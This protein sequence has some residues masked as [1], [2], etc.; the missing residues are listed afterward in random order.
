MTNI[1]IQTARAGSKSVPNKNELKFNGV[2]LFIQG[3]YNALNCE[4]ID[5]V[6][7]STDIDCSKYMQFL[8]GVELIN[9]PEHLRSDDCSH[10]DTMA[11]AVLEAEKSLNKECE[12]I[13]II[14]GNSASSFSAD[15][16]SSLEMLLAR[17]DLDSVMSVGKFNMFNPM[18]SLKLDSRNNLEPLFPANTKVKSSDNLR[19]NDKDVY[20]DIH[21][22]NGG[23]WTIRREV[24]FNNDGDFVFSWLGKNIG[25]ILQDSLFQE[26]DADWQ[27]HLV[28]EWQKMTYDTQKNI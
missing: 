18:R 16:A 2:P 23:F 11:H 27:L 28:D 14:L 15:L 4:K 9:R 26:I 10:Y 25:C 6:F 19:F 5:A 22:F 12:N 8:H 13:V 24:F 17:P 20:G 1:C 7:C 21:F 3:L